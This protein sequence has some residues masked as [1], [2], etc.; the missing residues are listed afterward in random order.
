M[1]TRSLNSTPLNLSS[2]GISTRDVGKTPRCLVKPHY[3]LL[4]EQIMW[5]SLKSTNSRRV[6]IK[7]VMFK[8]QV[9]I[10]QNKLSTVYQI[11]VE[12]VAAIF[13]GA[14]K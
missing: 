10:L 7:A 3:V 8:D 1:Y 9:Y 6:Q 13:L 12:K 5:F 2:S 11:D 14:T 4:F